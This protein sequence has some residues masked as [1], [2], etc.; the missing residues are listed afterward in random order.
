M[1]DIVINSTSFFASVGNKARLHNSVIITGK[2][3]EACHYFALMTISCA[4]VITIFILVFY[5]MLPRHAALARRKID[6]LW[7]GMIMLLM[8]PN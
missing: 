3:S 4:I 5:M 7:D 6:S 2:G 1:E 8:K